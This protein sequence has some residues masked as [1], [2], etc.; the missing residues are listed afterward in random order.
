MMQDSGF[1]DAIML[2]RLRFSYSAD[3]FELLVSLLF[4]CFRSRSAF[5][6]SLYSKWAW[7]RRNPKPTRVDTIDPKTL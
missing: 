1:S 5:L 4:F 6:S 7:N 2:F 3:L